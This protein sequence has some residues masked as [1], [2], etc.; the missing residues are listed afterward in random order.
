M[1]NKID[2]INHLIAFLSA[3]LGILIAFQ[4]EDYQDKQREKEE[5]Q[6]TLTAV[7]NEVEN[8]IKIYQT[9][10]EQLS[11]WLDYYDLYALSMRK[12][13]VEVNKFEF[14]ILMSNSRKDSWNQKEMVNDSIL[15]VKAISDLFII[16][17]AP[18]TGISSSSWQAGL[19][20]GSVNR[21]SY[22]NLSKL[23]S[24]ARANTIT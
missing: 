19:Y 13:D 23:T 5:L 22:D 24:G 21:L 1:K 16:D 17:T 9:N 20:S 8:N 7:K 6:I 4:L 3:L 15:V 11:A 14:D 18:I 12:G 2:W 10:I